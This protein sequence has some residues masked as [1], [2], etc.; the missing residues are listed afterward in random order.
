MSQSVPARTPTVK[1][2]LDAI[3]ATLQAAFC[4]ENFESQLVERHNKPEV[5][6]KTSKL[7]LLNP[8]IISRNVNERVL[9]EGSFNSIRVS[10]AVKQSD[11][12]KKLICK[13]LM[14]F[15]MQRAD[16][17]YILRR[18]PVPDYDISFLVTNFHAE[19]MYTHRLVDF[20]VY[21]LEEI[22]KEISEMNLAVSSRAR[23]MRKVATVVSLSLVALF[24]V[25]SIWENGLFKLHPSLMAVSYLGCMFQAIYIFSTD[26][27]F[28]S[29]S[30]TRRKQIFIHS[31]L[32]I[33]SLICS[34]I[35][36][37]AIYLNKSQRNKPHFTTWHGLIGLIVFIW[38]LLQAFAGLFLTVLQQYIHSLGLS[39]AQLRIYHAT[40][41]V[42]LFT[43]S[44]LV[45][46]LGLVSNWFKTK[47]PNNTIA[48]WM[49]FY[50]LTSNPSNYMMYHEIYSEKELRDVKVTHKKFESWHDR[51][52]YAAVQ[53]LR[54][55]FDTFT[56]YIHEP[57][58]TPSNSKQDNQQ[59]IAG[60]PGMVAG[61]SRHMK[62]LRTMQRDHGWI[63][64]LLSEAE[65]ERMHLLTFLELRQ[66]GWIFRTFVLLGQGVFFNAFFLTYLCSPKICH[67]FVG[68]LEEE[69]VITYTR[70]IE[71]L[72]AGRLPVWA[73]T[74]APKIAKTY[75]K[76]KDD[77]MMKDV[78]LAVRADEATHRQVNHKLAD[79]GSD[80]PNPYIQRQQDERDPPSE[81]EQEQINTGGKK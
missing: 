65:N 23:I 78:L 32:Q 27:A 62:S 36:F 53:T 20:I 59:S 31:T 38:S 49:I 46:V 3:R 17:F 45:L 28:R 47:M 68:F 1:P 2:Y 75:W 66:P 43:V 51:V 56:G 77:A 9:I 41:G 25:L 34:V 42:L 18:K 60:V 63:H 69:A 24:L 74:S 50:L 10:I 21:F 80:A 61:M 67:R 8:L 35:A 14:R 13:R 7:L 73:K 81:K 76:L 15:M 4:I 39:Y 11:E 26:D 16:D 30:L 70:C 44:C 5:E 52:A 72:E 19:T 55:T 48:Y 58:K 33:G 54:F 64:T 79:V 6:V 57:S 37:I 22:D 71:E 12:L 40:S 29:P